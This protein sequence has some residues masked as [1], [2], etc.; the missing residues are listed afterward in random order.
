MPAKVDDLV[1]LPVDLGPLHAED[2]AIQV[3]VLPPGQLG[4][5]AGA[6][7]QQRPDPPV[8][9][10][11]AAGRLG[12][13]GEDLQQR[14]LAGAVAAD[15]AENLALAHFKT[16]VPQRPDPFLIRASVGPVAIDPWKST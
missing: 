12:D 3:D 2:G 5:E 13:P 6:D 7:F 9:L 16:D 8:D 11:F 15:D 14:A 1:E 4:M 10:G